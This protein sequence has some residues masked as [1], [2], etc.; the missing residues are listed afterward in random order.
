[1]ELDLK[2]HQ[3]IG[4]LKADSRLSVRDIAKAT[5]IRPSTVH[6]RI[7]KLVKKG[8]IERFTLKLNNKAIGENFIVF[9]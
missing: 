2:D 6:E 4:L 5:G 8:I 3:I 7:K 1:M 9:N